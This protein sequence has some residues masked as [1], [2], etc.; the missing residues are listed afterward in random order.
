MIWWFWALSL[1][2]G[3][4]LGKLA[5]ENHLHFKIFQFPKKRVKILWERR[6]SIKVEC[7]D[8][9]VVGDLGCIRSI[10]CVHIWS[11]SMSDA[12]KSVKSELTN[13]LLSSFMP[14]FKIHCVVALGYWRKM[15]YN[16]TF[17]ALAVGNLEHVSNW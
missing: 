5:F 11:I 2:L 10:V 17:K 16:H 4:T 7:S 14:L 13:S 12:Y 15:F 3:I 8:S 6:Q 9:T 1:N